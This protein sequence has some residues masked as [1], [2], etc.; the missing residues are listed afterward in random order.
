LHSRVLQV[1]SAWRSKPLGIRLGLVASALRL[2]NQWAVLM[3]VMQ[4]HAHV[5]GANSDVFIR[6]AM[7]L[8]REKGYSL[9]N[10]DATIIAEVAQCST[11]H[12]AKLRVA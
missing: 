5:Q 6:E 7:R 9:G 10:L 1:L 8:M 2:Q 11:A 12:M 4:C 3:V